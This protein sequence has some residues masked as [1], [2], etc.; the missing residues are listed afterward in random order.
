MHVRAGNELSS[1]K[2]VA[3]HVNVSYAD[4]LR[5]LAENTE[6]KKALSGND[7]EKIKN[8]FKDFYSQHKGIY[9]IQWLDSKGTN[10]YGYPEENSLIN[11][12]VKTLKTRSSKSMLQA[13]SDKKESSFDSPLME[14]KKGA[15]FMVPVYNETEY[16]GMIYTI[17][18][19]D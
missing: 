10:R 7:S 16:I 15:F 14:G 12:D 8:I 18:L 5:T 19:K 11:F 9:S 17:K 1:R 2:D 13:L 6:M 3:K 4:A